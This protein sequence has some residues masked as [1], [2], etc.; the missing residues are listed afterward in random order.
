[1]HNTFTSRYE[2]RC[3]SVNDL[4]IRR[5]ES[6]TRSRVTWLCQGSSG[7]RWYDL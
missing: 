1:M 5:S 7:W 4:S 2:I 3:T 6:V